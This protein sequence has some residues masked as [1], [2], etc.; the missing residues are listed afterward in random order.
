MAALVVNN[1]V[2]IRLIWQLSG[3]DFAVNVMHAIKDNP[4]GTADQGAADALAADLQ[5]LYVPSAMRGLI[6]PTVALARVGVRDLDTPNNPEF[7]APLTGT[8]GN[9]ATDILPLN[10]ALCCTLRTDRAGGSYR[11]RYY[12]TGFTEGN[13][14]AGLA[15]PTVVT[16]LQDWVTRIQTAMGDN[17]YQL[18]VAS[19]KLGESNAVTS[20]I[21]RDNRWD[22]QR[23]RIVPGI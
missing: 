15:G 7:L 22:T 19:R 17:G 11:G 5:A 21:V 13:N 9:A 10:V 2:Q 6:H 1:T 4:L 20:I 18:S 16:G 8:T 14:T 23:R 12:Q 3:S